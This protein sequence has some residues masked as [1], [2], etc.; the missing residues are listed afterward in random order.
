[1]TSK[2]KQCLQ[3]A[4]QP[5]CTSM[6]LLLLRLVVG[7]AFLY[8]GWGKIQTPFSWMPPDAPIPGFFQFLAAISEFGGGLALLLGL[9]TRLAML[10]MG[11]TMLV[12]TATHKFMM[13]DPFVATEKGGGSYE[14]ALVYFSIAVLFLVVGPG[15]FSLDAKIFGEGACK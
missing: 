15:K 7:I 1:M 6:A 10:G 14:L 11:F 2:I 4:A 8:H 9:L 13:N 3:I 5:K 12:A